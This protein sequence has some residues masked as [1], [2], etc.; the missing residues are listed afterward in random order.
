MNKLKDKVAIVTGGSSGIGAGIARQLAADG[1]RVIV[2]YASNRSSADKVVA[3]IEAAGGR[4]VA[5]AAD[6]TNP[7]EVEALVNSAIGNLGRLDIVVN[8]AGIYQFARIEDSTEV[9]YRRQFDINVLGPLLL[10][11][12]ATPHLGKGSS[13]INISSFVTHV[14]IPESAIYSGTKGAIDAITSVLSRELGPRGIRVNA[15]NPGLIETEGS[16]I[17]GAMNSDFQIW[18]EKQTPLGRIGQ[19]QDVAPIVSFLASDDAGWVTGEVILASG[20]MR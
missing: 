2:N 18:N 1:A 3:D 5:V 16:H 13:I 9:L 6:V 8:N 4:A 14:A 12:A 19:V 20:G 11:G 17:S 15:V 10:V 7:S